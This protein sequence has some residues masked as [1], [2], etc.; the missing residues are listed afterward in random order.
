MDWSTCRMNR[1]ANGTRKSQREYR[2]LGTELLGDLRAQRHR[3]HIGHF[4]LL[5]R[6]AVSVTALP[7]AA[8][9]D[10]VEYRRRG[11][12]FGLDVWWARYRDDYREQ[13]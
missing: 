6:P 1:S 12:R 10:Y 5:G 13:P 2:P 9:T 11:G 3:R 8:L 4:P 7:A